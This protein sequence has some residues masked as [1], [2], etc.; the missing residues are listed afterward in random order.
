MRCGG[1]HQSIRPVFL[2]FAVSQ[3]S[4]P[5][6]ICI[7]DDN[8]MLYTGEEMVYVAWPHRA[9]NLPTLT[10]RLGI[11]YCLNRPC[12][13]HCV[14]LPASA[15]PEQA[16][17]CRPALAFL[18]VPG[19]PCCQSNQWKYS[20]SPQYGCAVQTTLLHSTLGG[21]GWPFP[22]AYLMSISLQMLVTLISDR[23][24]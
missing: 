18:P 8:L 4:L 13:L 17:R 23:A 19:L 2:C 21:A 3:V 1:D 12:S 15:S 6:L 10:G 22:P 11:V 20:L 14:S 9:Q 24:R 16:R 7:R 5:F